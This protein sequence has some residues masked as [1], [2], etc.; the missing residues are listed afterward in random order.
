MQ[1][2]VVC[3]KSIQL[4]FNSHYRSSDNQMP[5]PIIYHVGLF[6]T[7]LLVKPDVTDT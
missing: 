7:W 3:Y 1:R 6:Q 2:L 4:F 5:Y